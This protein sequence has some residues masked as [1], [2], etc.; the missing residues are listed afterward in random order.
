M[1]RA[2]L[3]HHQSWV[4]L[5]HQSWVV[6]QVGCHQ[7]PQDLHGLGHHAWQPS[8]PWQTCRNQ[9]G[10]VFRPAGFFTFSSGAAMRRSQNRFP[11]RRGGFCMPGTSGAITG[12]TDAVPV[13]SVGTAWRLDLLPLL[14]KAEARAWGE[15]T[16]VDTCLHPW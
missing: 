6:G 10:L 13:P 2:P 11:T 15:S 1:P 14:L 9:V 16:P 5:H 12:A 3:L 7:P 8:S 4:L